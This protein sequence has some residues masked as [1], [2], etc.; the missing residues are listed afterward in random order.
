MHWLAVNGAAAMLDT[1]AI[2][3]DEIDTAAVEAPDEHF[4]PIFRQLLASISAENKSPK[5]IESQIDRVAD[6]RRIMRTEIREDPRPARE[7][8]FSANGS[9]NSGTSA[10]TISFHGNA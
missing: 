9:T 6:R 8:S 10:S 7:H 4:M 5:S 1:L 3:V 2:H